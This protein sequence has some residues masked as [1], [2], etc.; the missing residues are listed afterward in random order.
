M[1]T[2]SSRE[3]E[4]EDPET[5]DGEVGE[6]SAEELT[7][8]HARGHPFLSRSPRL[9]VVVDSQLSEAGLRFVLLVAGS[10]SAPNSKRV[11]Q[12]PST[13]VTASTGLTT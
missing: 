2:N 7:C 9:P 12:S 8:R 11:R 13:A 1:P 6:V 3:D 5:D 10:S 4:A